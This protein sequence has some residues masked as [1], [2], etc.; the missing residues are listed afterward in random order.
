MNRVKPSMG[1]RLSKVVLEWLYSGIRVS[2]IAVR[3]LFLSIF[4]K[5]F[6]ENF[7]DT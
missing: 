3:F 7:A 4:G 6:I 5:T 2:V 1:T